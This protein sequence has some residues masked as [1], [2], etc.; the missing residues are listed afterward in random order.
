MSLLGKADNRDAA[1]SL[2]KG[3]DGYH[4]GTTGIPPGL[5]ICSKKIITQEANGMEK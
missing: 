4:K 3:E 5:H 1:L 2:S